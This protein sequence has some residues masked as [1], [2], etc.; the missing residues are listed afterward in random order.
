MACSVKGIA[1]STVSENSKKVEDAVRKAVQMPPV[2]RALATSGPIHLLTSIIRQSNPKINGKKVHLLNLSRSG[3]EEFLVKYKVG[4]DDKVIEVPLTSVSFMESNKTSL[5]VDKSTMETYYSDYGHS[6][7]EDDFEALALDITNNPEKIKEVAEYLVEADEYHNEENHNHI[8]MEQLGRIQ[9]TLVDMV[10]VL[11]V[12]INEVG[13]YNYGEI[14]VNNG[15]VYITKGVGGSKSL[16]EIYVH[17]LYHSITHF[18]IDSVS[19]E[20]R[21]VTARIEKVRDN[22]LANSTIEDIVKSSDNK[23]NSEQAGEL[24]DHLSDP[25]KGLHEF[26]ALSMTNRAIMTRLK[27]LNISDTKTKEDRSLFDTILDSVAYIFTT[28]VKK[29]SGEPDSNDLARMMFLVSKINEAHKKPLKAKQ[30]QRK[31]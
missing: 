14:E 28:V 23:L 12:H 15:D 9:E 17:E 6:H 18:A 3:K 31:Q 5:R 22:L 26:V 20:V 11:N 24:L 21:K 27:D 13:E 7:N 8:L 16:L 2:E 10:P 25:K 19:T 4:N 30:G 29:I 1:N